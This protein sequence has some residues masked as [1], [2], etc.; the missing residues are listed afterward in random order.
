MS[1]IFGIL[2]KNGAPI[3]AS[4][5]KAMRT[6]IEFWGPD[7]ADDW[8]DG[9]IALGH[10]AHHV[11]P[12]SS[13][14]TQ[15][16]RHP[17]APHV[18]LTAD[19]RLD[20]RVQIF[21][22][23]Q[24]DAVARRNMS[25][26]ELLLH[27]YLKWGEE[28]PRH[29]LGVF[30]FAI[31]DTSAERLFCARDQIGVR[32]LYYADLPDLFVFAS[33]VKAILAVSD[34]PQR[35]DD[36]AVW[37]AQTLG[38][39]HLKERTLFRDIS[40]LGTA[41]TLSVA[42]GQSQRCRYW[43]LEDV[44]QRTG[45]RT[46]RRTEEYVEALRSEIQ[47]AVAC[48]LRTNKPVGTHL[49]GGLDSSIIT[50][51]AARQLRGAGKALTGA[52]SWSPPPGE[53]DDPRSNEWARIEAICEQEEIACHYTQMTFEET[54]VPYMRDIRIAPTVTLFNEE[55]VRRNAAA[56]GV[57]VLLSG[58]GGDEFV[59]YPG[60][61]LLLELLRAGRVRR[62]WYTLNGPKRGV[63]SWLGMCKKH[64]VYPLLPDSLYARCVRA[65]RSIDSSVS[66]AV[67]AAVMRNRRD[68]RIRRSVRKTQLARFNYHYIQERLE[69]WALRGAETDIDYRYPFLDR[70]LIEFCFS[71][72]AEL[73]WANGWR[74]HLVRQAADVWLPSNVC[75]RAS[76]RDEALM[77]RVLPKLVHSR[78][79]IL[80]SA[81]NG[82]LEL[83]AVTC[84]I[85]AHIRVNS[86]D[87][88]EKTKGGTE[89]VNLTPCSRA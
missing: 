35:Q 66:Y 6:A 31:W 16:F 84:L 74:R 25:D 38:P 32:P 23:L 71:L 36:D 89:A 57:G 21:D 69:A 34:V 60:D 3:S 7:G 27:A 29:L 5:V 12:E 59:T 43:R 80:T 45:G 48:R 17:I 40:K 88:L 13:L 58:W 1:A 44:Q 52:Y 39:Q 78:D 9:H 53:G 51:L 73:F 11:T 18:T 85:P 4:D 62:L 10:L 37:R 54:L 41:Y 61:G 46:D 72:P 19:L 49:S 81:K 70:R 64:L 82:S 55:T 26:C 83:P 63:R 14:S 56:Q 8:R 50:V 77:T 30:A 67:R 79:H 22:A 47:R 24:I 86:N 2:R 87:G 28:T 75:W 65:E 76:K 20:N 33:D 15:P 42:R 68:A